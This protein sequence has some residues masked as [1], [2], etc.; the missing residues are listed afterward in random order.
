MDRNKA[1]AYWRRFTI[2]TNIE[3]QPTQVMDFNNFVNAITEWEN[4]SQVEP[5]VKAE[6]EITIR[7]KTI[8][9][10]KL[11]KFINENY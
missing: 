6:N 8:A 3:G 11:M 7:N 2:S 4:S 10:E 9:V 5:V 1:K